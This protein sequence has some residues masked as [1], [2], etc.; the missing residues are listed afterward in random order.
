MVVR[1]YLPAV[2]R[3][4]GHYKVIAY[5]LHCALGTAIRA[6]AAQNAPLMIYDGHIAGD[7]DAFYGALLF[8]DTAA[9]AQDPT[10]AHHFIIL[11]IRSQ[12]SP[13]I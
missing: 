2:I 12:T 8:A 9:N 6:F 10:H 5:F 3:P 1:F 11:L 4:Y 7:T 13:Y